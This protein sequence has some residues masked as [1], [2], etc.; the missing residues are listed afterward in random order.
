MGWVDGASAASITRAWRIS[1]RL[2][3]W[4]GPDGWEEGDVSVG[5]RQPRGYLHCA[6]RGAPT[7][8]YGTPNRGGLD[9]HHHGAVVGT[10]DDFHRVLETTAT[11]PA[12][13]VSSLV[14]DSAA[15]VGVE[16]TKTAFADG[17]GGC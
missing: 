12:C 7:V 3:T 10:V 14:L 11:P 16:A 13:R 6:G 4:V 9:G 2:T 15:R 8:H 1:R 5:L 17:S